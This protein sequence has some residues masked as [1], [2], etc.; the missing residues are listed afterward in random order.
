MENELGCKIR[1]L[2]CIEKNFLTSQNTFLCKKDIEG[3]DISPYRQGRNKR[4]K[5]PFE[6]RWTE[7]VGGGI[8]RNIWHTPIT[9]LFPVILTKKK[10]TWKVSTKMFIY[11]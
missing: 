6:I 7:H 5:N 3:W 1:Q 8:F 10:R 11:S 2:V 4:N 9:Q